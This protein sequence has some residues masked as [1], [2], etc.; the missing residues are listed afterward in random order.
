MAANVDLASK[1]EE[2]GNEV[3]LLKQG[4]ATIKSNMT[5]IQISILTL[6]TKNSENDDHW[7]RFEAMNSA[8]LDDLK[9][10][11]TSLEKDLK[12]IGASVEKLS[13][14]STTSGDLL[15][16]VQKE[17]VDMDSISRRNNII[18]FNLDE[19]EGMDTTTQVRN[20]IREKLSIAT[21]VAIDS[22]YRMK[23]NRAV[24][25]VFVRFGNAIDR[26]RV[27]TAAPKLQNS[28]SRV[29]MHEDLPPC[30]LS[31][32]R[33]LL[34]VFHKARQLKY[35]ASLRHD[36][37]TINGRTYT[38]DNI[39]SAPA[40]L[41]PKN[42]ATFENEEI[43]AFF[44][45]AS[46]L[47][48]FHWCNLEIEG[49]RYHSVEHYYQYKK[50]LYAEKPDLAKKI[51]DANHPAECKK[52][53]KN[54]KLRDSDIHWLPRAVEIMKSALTVKFTTYPQLKAEL[55]KTGDRKIVEASTD[56]FWG[57]GKRLSDPLLVHTA[58]DDGEG[59]NQLG[60]LHMELRANLRT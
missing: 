58:Y 4:F 30:I 28:G 2:L 10:A 53:A 51:Y 59:R 25:P 43:Y 52:L 15:D 14:M 32:R 16:K 13:K 57:C 33:Q 26:A 35:Q 1:I 8:D 47:S 19:S 6:Q 22:C 60:R 36:R 9:S 37:L 21:P 23:S 42:L 41:K 54:L 11:R 55:L 5:D 27:M 34:P 31:R 38:V 17:L 20:F 44:G 56:T 18:L 48:N 49:K 50:A 29:Q 45:Q 3:K 40:E 12:A 24:K 46:P 7:E 39:N